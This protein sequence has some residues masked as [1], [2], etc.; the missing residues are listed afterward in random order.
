MVT[1]LETVAHP[2]RLCNVV[3]PEISGVIVRRLLPPAELVL[4]STS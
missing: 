1:F 3:T 2:G 4:V